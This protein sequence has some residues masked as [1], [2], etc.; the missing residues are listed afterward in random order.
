MTSELLERT[1]RKW[2][3]S[4]WFN[5]IY[6]QYKTQT[7]PET[8]FQQ[9]QKLIPGKR[10]LDYGCGSGYLAARLAKGGYK[11]FTADVLDYRYEEARPY[12]SCRWHRLPTFH[13]LTTVWTW[14]GAGRAPPYQS[15]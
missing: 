5:Q 8:D 9:L 4:F 13:T 10:V 6:H 1:F 12:R 14:P 3:P 7:K 15:Q 2:D 11:V